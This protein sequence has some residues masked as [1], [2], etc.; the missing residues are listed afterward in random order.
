MK[1][2]FSSLAH[3]CLD[4]LV[5]GGGIYGAWATYDAALRGLQVALRTYR[6]GCRHVVSFVKIGTRRPPIS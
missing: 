3:P 2:D 1:R 6:L 5:V 4:L